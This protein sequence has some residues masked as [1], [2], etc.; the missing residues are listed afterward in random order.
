MFGKVLKLLIKSRFS[1][2]FLAI[3]IMILFYSL[4]TIDL[5]LT[6]DKNFAAYY[7]GFF[8]T[9]FLASAIYTGGISTTAADR[10]FLLTS[11]IGNRVLVPAFFLSQALASSLIFISAGSASLIIVK[12]NV[13]SLSFG[14]VDLVCMAILPISMSINMS[15]FSRPIRI[16]GAAISVLWVISSFFGV[17]IGPLSFLRG[18]VVQSSLFLILVTI[19]ATSISF[20]SITQE[21]L[22][23]KLSAMS[24]KSKG[25]RKLFSFTGHS[26]D[27]AVFHLHFKQ[28]DFSSRTAS[29]GNIK[30]K[31]N[32]VSIFTILFLTSVLAAALGIYEIFFDPAIPKS[33]ASP[34]AFLFL[35]PEAYAQWGLAMGLSSGTLSKERAWLAFISMPTE[36]Y[37]DITMLSKMMQALV[38]SLPFVVVNGIMAYLGMIDA[39][40]SILIFLILVPIYSGINFSLSFYKRTFQITQEDVL[41]STYNISQFRTMP[42][43]FSMLILIFVGLF[44]PIALPFVLGGSAAFLAYLAFNKNHWKRALYKMVENGYV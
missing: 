29:M 25:F 26:P 35:F 34:N 21:S 36:K 16:F 14:I 27:Y 20:R 43:S 17:A 38:V 32:R 8:F 9:L 22:P 19:V 15:S 44:I 18:E 4:L 41:P 33:L 10:D 2:G 31:V 30:I 37:L 39:V 6:D 13:F 24:S 12:N 42:I 5:G 7:L 11:A 40:S 3:I 28:V 1:R 23:Y